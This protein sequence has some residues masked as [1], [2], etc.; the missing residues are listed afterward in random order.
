MT[1]LLSH[2]VCQS[3]EEVENELHIVKARCDIINMFGEAGFKVL[4]PYSGRLN[5]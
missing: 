5:E 1:K 3:F 4:A 2:Y